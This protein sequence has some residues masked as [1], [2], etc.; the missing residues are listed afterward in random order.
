MKVKH[1]III[2][3]AIGLLGMGLITLVGV[4]SVMEDEKVFNLLGYTRIPVMKGILEIDSDINSILRRSYEILSK[5]RE[6]DLGERTSELRAVYNGQQD[7]LNDLKK[8]IEETDKVIISPELKQQFNNFKQQ[9]EQWISADRA[10]HAALGQALANPSHEAFNALNQQIQDSN[11]VRRE[12]RLGMVKTLEDMVLFAD[13]LNTGAISDA[14]AA[15]N[16]DFVTMIIVIVAAASVLGVF[17][18]SIMHSAIRPLTASSGIVT[19]IAEKLDLTLR[20]GVK[21]NDEIGALG[22]SFDYMMDH[23]QAAFQKIRAQIEDVSKTV[24]AVAT[25]ANEVAQSSANQSSSASAMAASI[26]EMS[27]SINTVSNSANEAQTM[28][29]EMGTI[30]EQGSQIIGQTCE[31]MANISRIVSSAAKVIETL[32]EESR[33]ITDVV[34]VIKEVAD[35]TNLLALNA[36][37]EAARAGE[38]GRGFAVVADEVRKLAERTAQSTVDIS[39]MVGKIQTS[40]VD[41]VSEMKKVVTQVES[42]QTLAKSAGERMQAIRDEAGRVSSAV[43]E[44]SDALKEQSEASHDVARHVESIAQMTAE[45]NAAAEES[46]T[47]AKRLDQLSGE[48]TETLSH[49]TVQQSA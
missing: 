19:E 33:Q 40:T 44:I 27:V 17:T 49:F 38:Q 4:R 13:K 2:M 48:V 43:T 45:N 22:H 5:E 36:A 35:Q 28:A 39:N 16:R 47:S 14:I 12:I 15:N 11:K 29:A 31:E 8:H 30:S 18:Y 23:L 1:R 46:A 9:F 34:N 25:G 26:E 32:G 42:G 41:A 6:H 24:E 20:L 37:I 10:A 7:K 21:G 3:F